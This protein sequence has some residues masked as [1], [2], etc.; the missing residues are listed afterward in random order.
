MVEPL[1]SVEEKTIVLPEETATAQDK[2]AVRVDKTN[3]TEEFATLDLNALPPSAAE[4]KSTNNLT[5]KE[6]HQPSPPITIEDANTE[7]NGELEEPTTIKLLL[8]QQQTIP[9]VLIPTPIPSQQC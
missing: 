1:I 7:G 8:Q 5:N 2:I 6:T 9:L 4:D 3:V